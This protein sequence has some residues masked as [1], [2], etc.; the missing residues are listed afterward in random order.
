MEIALSARLTRIGEL[1]GK[2]DWLRAQNRRLDEEADRL[3]EMIKFAPPVDAATAT[4]E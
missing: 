4:A 3:A 1:C 2:I